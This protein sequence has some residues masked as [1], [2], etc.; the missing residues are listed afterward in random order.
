MK[1]CV[2]CGCENHDDANFCKA[3][4]KPFE[5][6]R[7]TPEVQEE[8][9]A[10]IPQY[11]EMLR[12]MPSLGEEEAKETLEEM[13]AGIEE[14]QNINADL[15]MA[16]LTSLPADAD[17][18]GVENVID[19]S[20]K[21]ELPEEPAEEVKEA[22]E[23]GPVLE[24]TAVE[25]PASEETIHLE[26]PEETVEEVKE[27]VEEVPQTVE[28]VI[29]PVA[30]A[31]EETVEEVPETAEELKEEIVEEVKEAVEEPAVEE[32]KETV[33]ET[34]EQV[35]PELP[36]EPV[37]EEI[38]E[39][40]A[41]VEEPVPEVAEEVPAAPEPAKETAPQ[42]PLSVPEE[43]VKKKGNGILMLLVGLIAGCLI[44]ALIGS[45]LNKA[46]VTTTNMLKDYEFSLTGSN[47]TGTLSVT[48]DPMTPVMRALA[49]E[50]PAKADL[51]NKLADSVSCTVSGAENGSLKNGDALLFA[52]TY[53]QALAKQA[54]IAYEN[55]S[56]TVQIDGLQ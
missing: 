30:E 3:C 31:V 53:D 46:P 43:P 7:E 20:I 25:A 6:V 15:S 17:I 42:R 1:T 22:A 9:Q 37:T 41:T 39:E 19:S 34:P 28:E 49:A 47:G 54:G 27:A 45:Q 14:L 35:K 26:L 36:E 24:E 10:E 4:G 8:I 21:L 52:C 32:V 16:A 48:G 33:E 2:Y 44:G 50:D 11:G 51:V 5:V 12:S 29:E 38:P 40:P 13:N 56:V 23:E 55:T 18:S